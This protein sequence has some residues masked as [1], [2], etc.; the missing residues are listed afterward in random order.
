[1]NL[2]LFIGQVTW[3]VVH[4]HYTRQQ[5]SEGVIAQGVVAY[6]AFHAR[7]ISLSVY[8]AIYRSS[9]PENCPFSSSYDST[10]QHSLPCDI[11]VWPRVSK[12]N[13]Q[14]IYG[15]NPECQRLTP[16]ISTADTA[17]TAESLKLTPRFS[18]ADTQNL[19]PESLR[20]TRL[21]PRV[22]MT[23]NHNTPIFLW[24]L[25]PNVSTSHTAVTQNLYVSHSDSLQPAPRISTADSMLQSATSRRH[26][27]QGNH[28]IHRRQSYNRAIAA[29][30]H[31]M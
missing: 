15:W 14:N 27:Q 18:T 28:S 21:T 23:D 6:P 20:L 22:S 9:H 8:E 31:F 30:Q 4:F 17:D 12:A 16:K 29:H 24:R 25:T 7:F 5:S 26:L 3:R 1:M 10:V 11:T 19:Y 2:R 13:T